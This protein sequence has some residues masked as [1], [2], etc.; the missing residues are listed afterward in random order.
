V[1]LNLCIIHSFS[2]L[3]LWKKCRREDVEATKAAL[4]AAAVAEDKFNLQSNPR[5]NLSLPKRLLILRLARLLQI[6]TALEMTSRQSPFSARSITGPR[7]GQEKGPKHQE[8]G[9]TVLRLSMPGTKKSTITADCV[10]TT[11]RT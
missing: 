5:R 3:V 2:E 11:R 7:M 10:S 9:L 1:V 4:V 6:R 8:F